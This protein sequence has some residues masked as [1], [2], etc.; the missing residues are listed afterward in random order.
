M[1]IRISAAEA[2][3][4]LKIKGAEST[5]LRAA[6]DAQGEPKFRL[7]AL[8][9]LGAIESPKLPDAIRAA[10]TSPDKT[11]AAEARKLSGQL[12]GAAAVTANAAVL[13]KGSIAEQQEALA[14]LAKTQI[15]EADQILADQLDLLLADKLPPALHLDLL[16]AAS[17]R[18]AESI[19]TRLAKHEA[20]RKTNDPL[21]RWQECLEGGDAKL[22]R[23]IFAE[24]A[25]AGCMRCHAVKKE[26]GDV[27]PD[28][29]GI[30]TKYDHAYLLRAVVEPNAEI[31][32]GYENVLVTI[33]NGEVIAGLANKEDAETLTLKSPVDGKPQ[34]VKKSE[35]KDRQKLPS[36]MP[37]ALGD[38]LGKRALRDLIAYL[39]TLK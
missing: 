11:L 23:A 15:P 25:E 10:L 32:A 21:A 5:L 18:A 16:E 20:A 14:T 30:A 17:T 35:I 1:A 29:A 39:A 28:L 4:A 3:G 22:G 8:R 7:T 34:T 13:G 26:G 6:L 27:G 19:K 2:A 9:A 12:G 31:A 38:V 37:P 24:K 36:A 33:A